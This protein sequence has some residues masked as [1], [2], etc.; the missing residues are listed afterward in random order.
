MKVHGLVMGLALAA[1]G[2]AAWAQKAP[3]K[4]DDALKA[5]S[6]ANCE[7]SETERYVQF[8][9][10]QQEAIWYFTREGR[11]EHPAYRVMPDYKVVPPRGTLPMD[12]KPFSWAPRVIGQI[13]TTDREAFDKWMLAVFRDWSQSVPA[14]W[15]DPAEKQR[16]KPRAVAPS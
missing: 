6:N 10:K 2:G 16:A 4:Y 15:P 1:A 5:V 8:T 12:G 11:P 9:C 7:R 14:V 13:D 3:P